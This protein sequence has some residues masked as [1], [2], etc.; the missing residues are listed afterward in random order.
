MSALWVA[1][2]IIF[3]QD[4]PPIVAI[5]KHEPFAT[6]QEC[7]D[8]VSSTDAE[9][10]EFIASLIDKGAPIISHKVICILPDEDGKKS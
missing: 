7:N 1:Y 8:W 10:G 2:L 3:L 9:T 4:R 6:Q 5:G